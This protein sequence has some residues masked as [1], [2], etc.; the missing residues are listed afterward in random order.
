MFVERCDRCPQQ[1][2]VK[3]VFDNGD[4][5]LCRHDYLKHK[6]PIEIFANEI[7]DHTNKLFESMGLTTKVNVV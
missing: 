4:L 1:A 3:A 2:W 5:F 6:E 7:E